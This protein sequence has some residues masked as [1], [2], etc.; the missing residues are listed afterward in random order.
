VKFY[1]VYT[2]DVEGVSS[3]ELVLMENSLGE[4]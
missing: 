4:L 2:I 1:G 3:I